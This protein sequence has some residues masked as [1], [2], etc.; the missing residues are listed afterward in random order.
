M[1]AFFKDKCMEDKIFKAKENLAETLDMPRDVI[2][3]IPKI[4]IVGNDE[5]TIENHKGIIVFKDDFIKIKS[6]IGNVSVKG[7]D[8]EILFISGNT[9]VLSGNFKS[10]DYEGKKNGD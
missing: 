10:I 7:S 6:N 4:T 8:F 2:L 5:I 1:K 9:I 3:K